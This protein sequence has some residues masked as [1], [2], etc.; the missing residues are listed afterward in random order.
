LHRR[1][2]YAKRSKD[3]R[4]EFDAFTRAYFKQRRTLAMVLMLVDASIPPQPVD[5]DYA[6]WLAQSSVPFSIVFTK[7]DKRKRGGPRC[8]ENVS[9]FKRALL[10]GRGFPLVPPS[11][12][13]SASTGDGKAE[14]LA[15]I[16][17][18]RRMWEAA[19]R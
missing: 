6:C 11:I 10:E 16:A 14:L 12:V 8:S 19:R 1:H 18:L 4:S 17:S 2:S 5:L 3:Q 13:T 15:Y 7:A 9:A